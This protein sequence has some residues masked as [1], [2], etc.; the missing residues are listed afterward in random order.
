MGAMRGIFTLLAFCLLPV[1]ALHAASLFD[2]AGSWAG[3]YDCQQGRTALELDISVTGP[4]TLEALFYFH[5]APENPGVPD[6]CF[7]MQG[8]MVPAENLMVLK[9]TAWLKQPAGYVAVGLRGQLG[10]SG[11]LQGRIFG[12]GCTGF[13]LTR[14]P[15]PTAPAPCA[16]P[17][18]LGVS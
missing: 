16:P 17:Q 7:L 1:S 9:P 5:A 15:A 8:K 6:G 12:P 18:K 14:Q 2:L 4:Q 10:P 3:H 11:L 13:T